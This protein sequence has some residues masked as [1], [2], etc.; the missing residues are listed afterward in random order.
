[1]ALYLTVSV[2]VAVVTFCVNIVIFSKNKI[3]RK[4]SIFIISLA[5]IVI[6]VFF[7][8]ILNGFIIAGTSTG[9]YFALIASVITSLALIVVFSGIVSYREYIKEK[10]Q[11]ISTGD[12]GFFVK[13]LSN[14][15]SSE[16]TVSSED[17]GIIRVREGEAFR[18]GSNITAR[19]VDTKM[20]INT[21]GV[22]NNNNGILLSD[23]NSST[24]KSS[25][26]DENCPSSMDNLSVG[27]SIDEEEL[28]KELE[29]YSFEFNDDCFGEEISDESIQFKNENINID[30]HMEESFFDSDTYSKDFDNLD[31]EE[32][33]NRSDYEFLDDTIDE[34]INEIFL[35]DLDG[36]DT[37]YE[38]H[39]TDISN[40]WNW[41]E[42]I[43]AQKE[44]SFED[45]QVADG[46]TCEVMSDKSL[47]EIID[48]GFKMKEQG[49]YE[50]AIINFLYALDNHPPQDVALWMLLDIC[51][52]YKQLGQVELAKKVLDNYVTEY[53]ISMDEALKYEIE[54]NLQ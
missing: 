52:M 21:I 47:Y 6:I 49:D 53:G 13:W 45:S 41:D 54:L 11:K 29:S 39:D 48:E 9:F 27:I 35:S 12:N 51:V 32:V 33:I 1:M 19:I 42:L 16:K 8:L 46:K 25:K 26:G 24:Q 34:L 28:L 4:D 43:A 2:L 44:E 5:S 17:A 7:P 31:L 3:L 15:G 40:N 23:N 18:G 30:E 22:E 37:N 36:M 50:G 38:S 20:N 14:I 10:G